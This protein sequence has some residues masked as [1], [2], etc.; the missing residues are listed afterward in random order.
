MSVQVLGIPTDRV[1]LF[2]N[3]RNGKTWRRRT[4]P[5]GGTVS[6]LV[7]GWKYLCW[8]CQTTSVDSRSIKRNSHNPP[9]AHSRFRSDH[10]VTLRLF[11]R[12]MFA[13]IKVL[14]FFSSQIEAKLPQ[15]REKS[16]KGS[17]LS[18]LSVPS[19]DWNLE[20]CRGQ[21]AVQWHGSLPVNV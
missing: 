10:W 13:S 12:P 17:P 16:G 4:G 19:R 8:N 7:R 9:K 18:L 1:F 14:L 11:R 3:N 20:K 5:R 21:V 15:N 2:N 6:G